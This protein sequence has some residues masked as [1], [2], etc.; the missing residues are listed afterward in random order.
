MNRKIIA[1]SWCTDVVHYWHKNLILNCH[2][3]W[4]MQEAQEHAYFPS[5]Q[6]LQQL[7]GSLIICPRTPWGKTISVVVFGWGTSH[8]DAEYISITFLTQREE[9]EKYRYVLTHDKG[10]MDGWGSTQNTDYIT[11]PF[12]S[13]SLPVQWWATLT[14]FRLVLMM[15]LWR[16]PASLVG[17]LG[18]FSNPWALV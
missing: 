13:T 12:Y 8:R 2:A 4:N 5:N 15:I 17:S 16:G 7:F 3:L 1:F 18:S 14:G 10:W 6:S 11:I 9:Q